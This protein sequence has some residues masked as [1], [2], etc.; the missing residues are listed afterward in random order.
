MLS[1]SPYSPD[2]VQADFFIAMKETRFK[3]V[4]S[5]Q[6]SV[7]GKLKAVWAFSSLYE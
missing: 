6:W 2:L 7:M 3:A 5:I 4:S 1:H